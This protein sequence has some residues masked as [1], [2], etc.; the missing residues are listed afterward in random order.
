M[1]LTW[2]PGLYAPTKDLVK[3]VIGLRS[4]GVALT[5]QKGAVSC[6]RGE[7]Q[8][9]NMAPVADRTSPRCGRKTPDGS[10][11]KGAR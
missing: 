11:E 3:G 10:C 9:L 7:R 8:R 1:P 2:L 5:I 6:G 4:R